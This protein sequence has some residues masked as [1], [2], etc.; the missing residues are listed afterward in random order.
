MFFFLAATASW[1]MLIS[2]G[3]AECARV[4]VPQRERPNQIRLPKNRPGRRGPWLIEAYAQFRVATAQRLCRRS[5]FL[6]RR[7]P[8]IR[9]AQKVD[10]APQAQ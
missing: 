3:P 5:M 9:A 10:D 2:A 1:L 6:V 7:W 4:S 8:V